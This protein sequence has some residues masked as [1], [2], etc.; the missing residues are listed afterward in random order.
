M[1]ITS[2]SR[3]AAIAVLTVAG[4]ISRASDRLRLEAAVRTAE[5]EG[6][7][8]VLIDLG[9]VQSLSATA[10]FALVE[11]V[12]CATRLRLGLCGLPPA[13]RAALGKSGMDRFLPLFDSV[14]AAL[15]AD[16]FRDCLLAGTPA[17]VLCAG[18]GSR[19]APLSETTPKP[20]LDLLGKPVLHRLIDHLASFGIDEV[21]LNPGHLGPQIPAYFRTPEGSVRPR[22]RYTSEGRMTDGGWTSAP[23]GSA[24]TLARLQAA[25]HA[26]DGDVVVMCG[27]A[28]V[29]LDLSAMMR[30]HRSSGADVTI[31]AQEV[32]PQDVHRYGIIV[33]DCTGRVTSFQEK[34]RTD[35]A[36][37]RL[38]NTGIYIIRSSAIDA[39]EDR[40]DQ[41][42][43][44]HLL[45]GILAR[46]GRLQVWRERFTWLDIGCGR[47]YAATL[48][49]GLSGAIAGL[50]PIAE[51]RRGD[52]FVAQGA[53]VARGARI[54]GPCYVGPGA[55]IEAGAR[56]VGPCVI[57]AGSRIDARSLVSDCIVTA[58]THVQRGAIAEGLILSADWAV[59]HDRADG[60]PQMRD[61]IDQVTRVSAATAETAPALRASA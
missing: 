61:P 38:A 6:H 53:Q 39:L 57:G 52:T 4:D 12:T 2:E 1:L 29:D 56:I 11:L 55:V 7:A 32:A 45:A 42:I 41:D 60:S 48:A 13:C 14:D 23:I 34:P 16:D 30:L 46:G 31:A 25:Q 21:H 49:A 59:A 27:D 50:A 15:G 36:L 28:W 10:A 43:A 58:G 51:T 33:S 9:R 35:E 17:V 8:A 22:L 40:P 26:F 24:S 47:D 5:H 54:E 3:S 19:I 20:M 44:E 37:S 18:K